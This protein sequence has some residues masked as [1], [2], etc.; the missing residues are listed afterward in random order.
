MMEPTGF[1]NTLDAILG[2]L[3]RRSKSE[4]TLMIAAYNGHGTPEVQYLR[5]R[6]MVNKITIAPTP[7]D[8]AWLNFRN[9]W[10]R[11]RSEEVEGAT[12]RA[13]CA[14]V[15]L[16]AVTDDEGYFEMTFNQDSPL[17][18]EGWVE[19]HL[20]LL[21]PH[22]LEP[23][24]TEGQVWVVQQPEYGVISDIDD[25]VLSTNVALRMQMVFA[26][27]FK[28]AFSR[29]PFEGVAEFYRALVQGCKVG[30][31]NPIFYVS[32]SPWNLYD[33]LTDFL[34]LNS[35]PMGTLFL[36][37]WSMKTLRAGHGPHKLETIFHI[38]D[39][40]PGLDFVLIG[41]SGE[42]DP[43]IYREVA[44]SVQHRGRIRAIYIRVVRSRNRRRFEQVEKIALELAGV[45]VKMVMVP[46]TATA[47]EHAR[48]RG[49]IK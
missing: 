44:L 30:S 1:R 29:L 20:E 8:S 28:N 33:L 3:Y 35:I 23:V 14:G 42:K 25:T 21:D 12:V 47:V 40:H 7:L 45:G 46:D 6:V 39:T 32:S 26:L 16:E 19:V 17:L 27:L 15:T 34:R 18:L 48:A 49:L 11:F 38:L 4:A 13:T 24:V 31:Q 22:T 10:R 37:D 9:T 36:R 5:G 43:D 41:D 2:R